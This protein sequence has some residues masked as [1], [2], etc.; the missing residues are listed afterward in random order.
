MFARHKSRRLIQPGEP[1]PSVGWRSLPEH[2]TS[3][4]PERINVVREV[5]RWLSPVAAMAFKTL[6]AF[7]ITP[8]TAG[9]AK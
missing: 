9:G 7:A 8:V 5:Y 6:D 1:V 4:Q 2:F 3:A